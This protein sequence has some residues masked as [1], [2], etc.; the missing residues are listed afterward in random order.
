MHVLQRPAQTK[1][2]AVEVA[3]PHLKGEQ[4][5]VGR[6]QQGAASQRETAPGG[7]GV[8]EC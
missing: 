7:V 8:S 5:P 4:V 6:E 2:G 1:G 3:P